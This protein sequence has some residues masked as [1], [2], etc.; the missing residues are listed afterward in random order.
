MRAAGCEIS[1]FYDERERQGMAAD[2][3]P[4]AAAPDIGREAAHGRS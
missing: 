1:E 2:L 4:I 3:A